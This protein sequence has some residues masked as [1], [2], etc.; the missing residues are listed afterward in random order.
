MKS[1]NRFMGITALVLAILLIASVVGGTVYVSTHKGLFNDFGNI[2]M[3]NSRNWNMNFSFN[4]KKSSTF[5]TLKTSKSDNFI[6]AKS[7]VIDVAVDDITFIEEDRGDI[8]VEYYNEHPDSPLYDVTYSAEETDETL[9]INSTYSVS[10][11]FIDQ[12]YESSITIHVPQDYECDTLDVTMSMGDLT[13]DSIFDGARNL[14]I[15]SNLGSINLEVTSPKDSLSVTCDMGDID[16]TISAPIESFDAKTNFG[17]MNIDIN[18]SVG[19]LWCDLDMGSL[20]INSD[21]TI[22]NANMTAK[23]GSLECSFNER[24]NKL[25]ADANMGSINIDFGNNSDSTVYVNTNAGSIDSD[26]PV[27]KESSDPDFRFYANMGS[28]NIT[29]H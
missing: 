19:S 5:E 26:L 6:L 13:D 17:E 12:T 9:Y 15:H 22:D 29:S 14:N 27:V 3:F 23:M 7:L 16:L 8:L 10:N 1:M 20:T 11:L 18:D 25:T 4:G 28:I 24:V 2:N 21:G